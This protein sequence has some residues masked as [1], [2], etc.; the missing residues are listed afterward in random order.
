[1]ERVE[2]NRLVGEDFEEGK[3]EDPES[4]KLAAPD[5][6][7]GPYRHIYEEGVMPISYP[8]VERESLFRVNAKRLR[9]LRRRTKVKDENRRR[10]EFRKA[11]AEF[12][13]YRA[14]GAAL[15]EVENTVSPLL[16]QRAIP[17]NTVEDCRLQD[18]LE[19]FKKALT[20][21]RDF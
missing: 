5:L 20:S 3:E 18:K 19:K 13:D 4:P 6:P 16:D 10:E 1:M 9:K 8:S 14:S 2:V 15:E 7:K 12:D 21:R 11:R 17:F